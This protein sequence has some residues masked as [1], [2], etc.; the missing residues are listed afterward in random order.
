MTDQTP[1]RTLEEE[2]EYATNHPIV[3]TDDLEEDGGQLADTLT[4]IAEKN[5]GFKPTIV[6][7]L[8]RD[9]Q[10]IAE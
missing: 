10:E 3:T 6:Q 2:L 4:R 1:Q 9:N 8:R 7:S 5:P